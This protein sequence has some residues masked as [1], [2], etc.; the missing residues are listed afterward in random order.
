[1]HTLPDNRTSINILVKLKKPKKKTE[2]ISTPKIEGILEDDSKDKSR[3]KP[4][5]GLK[6]DPLLP[7]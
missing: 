4:I 3:Q 1:M 7:F 2:S 6:K 5:D